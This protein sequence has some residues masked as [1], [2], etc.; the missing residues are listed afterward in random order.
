MTQVSYFGTRVAHMG[1]G[2]AIHHAE[3]L[4][5]VAPGYA[6]QIPVQSW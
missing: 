5:L 3:L 4:P 1:L 2:A 6:G